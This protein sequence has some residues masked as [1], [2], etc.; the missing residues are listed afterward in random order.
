MAEQSHMFSSVT[1]FDSGTGIDITNAVGVTLNAENSATRYKT[2]DELHWDWAVSKKFSN[3]L[4]V[5]VIGYVY[6]QLT[7]DSGP[8]A[9]LGSFKGHVTAVGGSLGYDFK[10]GQLPVSTRARYYHEFDVQNRFEGDALFLSA[11]MPLWVPQSAG[12]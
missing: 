10:I 5:G 1:Y 7:A 9:S 4:S 11:S 6:H 2:G 12:R 8:G 3:C